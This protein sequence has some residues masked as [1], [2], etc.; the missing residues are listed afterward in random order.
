VVH[1]HTAVD[2]ATHYGNRVNIDSSAAYGG[3]VTAVV[4]EGAAV[5]VLGPDGRRPLRP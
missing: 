4:I 3:P 1:G 5:W 2:A